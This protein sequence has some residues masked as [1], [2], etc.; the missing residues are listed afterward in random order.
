MLD[1]QEFQAIQD[2]YRIGAQAVKHARVT[3]AR[4]LRE[5]DREVLYGDVVAQYLRATGVSDVEPEEILRHRLS[6][7]GPPCARCGEELRSPQ[8]RKCLE[9]GYEVA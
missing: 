4:P 9:C 1:D 3:E 2:A 8:A 7:L 6:R 5:S